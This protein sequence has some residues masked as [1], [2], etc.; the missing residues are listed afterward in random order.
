MTVTVESG[1][2]I[3][4]EVAGDGEPVLLICG[5][6]ADSTFWAG[7]LPLLAGR[8]RVVTLDPRGAGRSSTPAGSYGLS[9]SGE[10]VLAVLRAAGIPRAHI[11]G[12]S[13]GAGVA[14]WLAWQ[15]PEVVSTLVLFNAASRLGVHGRLALTA[16]GH[17]YDTDPAPIR[18]L[19]EALYPWLFSRAYLEADDNLA[20]LLNAS[21]QHPY[22][23]SRAGYEGQL[24]VLLE[25][26]TRPWLP[27]IAAPTLVVAAEHDVL[28]PSDE[29]ALLTRCIPGARLV[30]VAGAGHCAPVEQPRSC[31]EL[32]VGHVALTPAR[33]G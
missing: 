26:D 28:L 20:L 23:Q 10:D 1:V 19:A 24:Q 13:L 15:H 17:F 8:H 12:H 2:E 29:A 25:M 7:V 33:G 27:H 3:Y 11:V 16:A 32:I 21:L 30:T 18:L 14:Q 9:A 4:F 22:P 6:A 5:F 31:A